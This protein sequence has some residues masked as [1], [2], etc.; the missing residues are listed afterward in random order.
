MSGT[1]STNEVKHGEVILLGK[2]KGND[3]PSDLSQDARIKSKHTIKERD[4]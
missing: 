3:H 4:V 1:C 2:P